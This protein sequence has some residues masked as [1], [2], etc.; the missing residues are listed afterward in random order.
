MNK[1]LCFDLRK[2]D[3]K[4]SDILII[5]SSLIISANNQQQRIL[6]IKFPIK[7]KINLKTLNLYIRK[8]YNLTIFDVSTFK[9]DITIIEYG[10]PSYFLNVTA[11]IQKQC[12]QNNMINIPN[13]LNLNDIKGDPIFG[14]KKYLYISY[15]INEYEFTDKFIEENNFLAQN[16]VY[17]YSDDKF[18]TN[19]SF[20]LSSLK[21]NINDL[22][23]LLFHIYLTNDKPDNSEITDSDQ[24]NVEGLGTQKINIIYIDD[25]KSIEYGCKK[26]QWSRKIYLEQLYE[27][28]IELIEKYTLKDE[29]LYVMCFS[30]DSTLNENI[31][32]YLRDKSYQY[33]YITDENIGYDLIIKCN[34]VYIANL[35]SIK[36]NNISFSHI[37]SF[38][39][40]NEVKQV[41]LTPNNILYKE[42]IHYNIHEK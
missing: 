32:S 27:K 7:L 41:L 26:N 29:L 22:N 25:D 24:K 16:V 9:F 14:R 36:S 1:I 10:I 18:L 4:L 19:P 28:Y 3:Y 33:S 40:S 6:L 11:D 31:I 15:K 38:K 20:Q 12:I 37:I 21:N 39:L 2:S 30:L 34:N 13:T 17:N 23:K 35:N 5:L 42:L 8:F